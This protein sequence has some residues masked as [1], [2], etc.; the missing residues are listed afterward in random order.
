[1]LSATM[2]IQGAEEATGEFD[3]VG[4][5][6]VLVLIG[7]FAYGAKRGWERGTNP[8][9]SASWG[10]RLAAVVSG[11][12]AIIAVAAFVMNLLAAIGIM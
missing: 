2:I 8:D 11:G 10:W 12:I 9:G 4:T 7:L 5:L 3:P 6:V 1:M